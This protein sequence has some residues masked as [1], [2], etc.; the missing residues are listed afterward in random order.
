LSY[1]PNPYAPTQ[2]PR[3]KR[4]V[5]PWLLLAAAVALG[6]CVA[7]NVLGATDHNA[8]AGRFVAGTEQSAT[9]APSGT[10]VLRAAPHATH[11][12]KPKATT[13]HVTH[14]PAIKPRAKATTAKPKPKATK[15]PARTSFANCT[16]LRRVYP[17]GVPVGHP[18]YRSAMDRDHDGRACER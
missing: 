12:P 1:D 6:V 11:P 16:E 4:R 13:T 15:P 18:A 2:Y 17:N 7:G 3:R 8:T 10:G 9:A 14:A 5:W